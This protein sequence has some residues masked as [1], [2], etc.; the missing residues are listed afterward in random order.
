M[1]LLRHAKSAICIIGI[2][3]DVPASWLDLTSIFGTIQLPYC[4][5]VLLLTSRFK[6]TPVQYTN[7]LIVWCLH[8]VF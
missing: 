1:N 7:I 8:G 2:I 5:I 3:I 4:V 6:S